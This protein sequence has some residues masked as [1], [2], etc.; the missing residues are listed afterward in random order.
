MSMSNIVK[1]CNKHHHA[2]TKNLEEAGKALQ[3]AKESNDPAKIRAGIDEAQQ[4]LRDMKERM[5]RC[6]NMMKMM[7]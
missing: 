7:K 6:G 3:G 2:M 5:G 1:E 4:Q